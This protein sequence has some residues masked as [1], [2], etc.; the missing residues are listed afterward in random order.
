MAAGKDMGMMRC[1]GEV[2]ALISPQP[3]ASMLA[4]PQRYR[5]LF[6]D[7]RA[8]ELR[9]FERF[10]FFPIMHLIVLK[11]EL[12]DRHP[13]LPRELIACFEQAKSLAYNYYDDSNY[14]LLVDARM[15]LEQQ[16]AEFGADPWPNGLRANAKNLAQFIG[17]SHDQRLIPAPFP[18]QRLFHASTHD[19]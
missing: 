18:P 13:E 14:S 15:L 3:R 5:R 19:S 4:R 6:A 1:D 2:E 12:A 17:Y 8:E 10:G 11:R 9:Y 16:R 7:P